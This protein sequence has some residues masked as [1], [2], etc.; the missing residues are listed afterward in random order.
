MLTVVVND[1]DSLKI[2]FAIS[3]QFSLTPRNELRKLLKNV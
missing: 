2:D 3:C 1:V